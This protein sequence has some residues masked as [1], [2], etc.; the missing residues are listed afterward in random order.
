MALP[1]RLTYTILLPQQ[2]AEQSATQWQPYQRLHKKGKMCKIK[3]SL[4]VYLK[5]KN[6][7]TFI[8]IKS[9][10]KQQSYDKIKQW[11]VRAGK[12]W[13]EWTLKNDWHDIWKN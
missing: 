1:S 9:C 5:K 8:W 13:L 11:F 3:L 6:F 4:K 2:P 7:K 12:R 10:T